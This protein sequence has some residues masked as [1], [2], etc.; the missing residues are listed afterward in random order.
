MIIIIVKNDILEWLGNF[1]IRNNIMSLVRI[2][3]Y[4][5]VV[6]VKYVHKASLITWIR[7]F[8]KL[9]VIFNVCFSVYRENTNRLINPHVKGVFW[10]FFAHSENEK[11]TVTFHCQDNTGYLFNVDYQAV[12]KDFDNR[13]E[14]R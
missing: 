6:D 3:N 8:Q 4:M 11:S 9:F 5:L 10:R 1:D 14:S 7:L 12:Y 2:F 13:F